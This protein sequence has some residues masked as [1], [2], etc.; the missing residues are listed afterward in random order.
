MGLF[1]FKIT[2]KWGYLVSSLTLG[3]TPPG[4]PPGLPPRAGPLGGAGPPRA[5]PCEPG[6]VA[7]FPWNP[8]NPG[9]GEGACHLWRP[10]PGGPGAGHPGPS[11]GPLAPGEHAWRQEF[12]MEN[13]I[14]RILHGGFF[15]ENSLW[16]ILYWFL[17]R[18]PHKELLYMKNST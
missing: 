11:A 15:I 3:A 14:L 2:T 4:P 13:S 6:G 12:Y 17:Y 1:G 18:E 9:G 16:G 10:A 8:W 5:H 7:F